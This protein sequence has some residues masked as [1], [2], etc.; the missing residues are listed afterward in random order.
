MGERQIQIAKKQR[1]L[2]G[3]PKPQYQMKFQHDMS[4]QPRINIEFDKRSGNIVIDKLVID[5]KHANEEKEVNEAIAFIEFL[6]KNFDNVM[7]RMQDLFHQMVVSKMEFEHGD[8]EKWKQE[9]R[10]LAAA[11]P[12]L[13]GDLDFMGGGWARDGAGRFKLQRGPA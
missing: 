6:D 8:F 3:M 12:K 10:K 11:H 9:E 4:V 1:I 7:K 5:I 2:P 13:A